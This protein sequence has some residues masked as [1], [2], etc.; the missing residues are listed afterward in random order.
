MSS[1]TAFILAGGKSSRMGRDK[2]FVSWEGRTLLERALELAGQIT[3]NLRIVG[4]RAKFE[5]LGEVVEDIY[6]GRGPLGGIHAAL[7]ATSTDLNLV[8]AVDLPC[9]TPALLQYLV[10]E[11]QNSQAL[12]AVPR[13]AEGWQPLCAVY[14]KGFATVAESALREGR[15]AVHALLESGAPRVFDEAELKQAGFQVRMFRNINT[16]MDLET[17]ADP[18]PPR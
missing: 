5:K 15:N 3:P 6:P 2:A 17:A 13:L 9:V 11:A 8:L 4:A 18:A 10:D 14:R 12:V 1:V 7:C 16:E